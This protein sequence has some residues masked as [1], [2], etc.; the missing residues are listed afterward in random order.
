MKMC[1]L[2]NVNNW[3]CCALVL[4]LWYLN[5]PL[6]FCGKILAKAY[7]LHWNF[8]CILWSATFLN[9]IL[10]TFPKLMHRGNTGETRRNFISQV[11]KNGSQGLGVSGMRRIKVWAPII[12][13][14]PSHTTWPIIDLI[15]QRTKFWDLTKV[16]L[17]TYMKPANIVTWDK[18][19][20]CP[21]Q[22]FKQNKLCI[23]Y[24]NL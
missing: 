5:I 14:P 9:L 17:C 16:H 4:S 3:T 22:T 11:V 1:F 19:V 18:T 6:R 15:Y 20:I 10:H 23:E 2:Q 8:C 13:C 7:W 21:I 12:S 24:I